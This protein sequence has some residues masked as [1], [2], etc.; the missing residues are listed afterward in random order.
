MKPTIKLTPPIPAPICCSG[1]NPPHWPAPIRSIPMVPNTTSKPNATTEANLGYEAE[2]RGV[3]RERIVFASKVPE[4]SD[5]LSRHHH[6]DLF[7]DTLPYNAH[8]TASDALWAGL[9]LV[10][11]LGEAFAGRVAASLLKAVGLPE[12]ITTSLE[13]YE[14]LALRL[15]RDPMLLG[16][17]K[18]KLLRNQPR[19][20]ERLGVPASQRV[21]TMIASPSGLTSSSRP[22]ARASSPA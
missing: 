22:H 16:G 10:T 7:L 6:G 1:P 8:T 5:H 2:R 14:G 15:A 21:V 9:P 18:D 17:I 3:S 11:C 20:C 12:L 13:D 4:L 19:L